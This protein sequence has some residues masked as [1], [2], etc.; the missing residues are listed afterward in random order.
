[1]SAPTS[2]EL[3]AALLRAVEHF[4]P[5]DQFNRGNWH[6]DAILRYISEQYPRQERGPDFDYMVLDEW[7]EL[8]RTGHLVWGQDL[9]NYE[10][11]FFHVSS[12]GEL[13]LR[14]LARDPANQAG[15]LA[16][17][18]TEA[19]PTALARAYIE[20][21]LACFNSGFHRAAAVMVGTGVE[22]IVLELRDQLAAR[23]RT[24]GASVPKDLLDWRPATAAGAM[25]RILDGKKGAMTADLRRDYEAHW[26]PLV[27]Q[28][29]R[30]RNDA[31]HPT[32]IDA[33]R[34]EEVHAVLLTV[35][36]VA[37]LAR[38]LGAWM[39]LMP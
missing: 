26:S 27:A 21:G 31:G 5:P 10:R 13:A 16:Y 32:A 37:R 4:R 30:V 9:G 18:D 17:L 12:R 14:Q 36:I 34:Y 15:Y 23:L 33:I 19:Q 38:Q 1:M 7:S 3:R 20:E 24:L 22:A 39:A 29:R 28:T 6:A 35:P 11:A 8:F 2:Q 25:Q